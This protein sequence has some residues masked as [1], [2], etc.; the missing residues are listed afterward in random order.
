VEARSEP[1]L[2]VSV[3]IPCYNSSVYIAQTVESVMAQTLRDIEIVFVDDGSQ[4]HTAD[5]IRQII[6]G[7]SRIPMKLICQSNAGVA[8]ARN[9]GIAE[10]RGRFV[11]PLDA[12]DLI[13][14]TM[15]EECFV[16]LEAEPETAI[17]YTNR[18][19]FGDI[20]KDEEAGVF[21]LER[22]KYF[23]QLTYCSMFRKSMWTALGGYRVNV[24]GF[25]DWDFWIA[26]ALCGYRA[27]H[28]PRSLVNHRRRRDSTLW[29][30]LDRYEALFA[31]IMLNNAGAYSRAELE[32]ARRFDLHKESS[33]IL[34]A[35][36]F[37]FLNRY[38]EGYPCV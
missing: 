37:V 21:E 6:A 9:R 25:D 14:N 33:P 1:H 38:Y 8:A 17:V 7:A 26:A 3:V 16:R 2:I 13:E 23:N 10:A 18:H 11:L 34:K 31:R 36:K 27:A 24:S 4:D 30:L 28:I 12:D 20:D 29:G 32:A 35:S 19:D 22:L 15:L 5:A